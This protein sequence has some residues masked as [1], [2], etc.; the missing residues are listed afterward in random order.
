MHLDNEASPE[1]H[2]LLKEKNINY[3]LAPPGMYRKNAAERAIDTFKDHFIAV[4]CATDPDLLM[5]NRDHLIK[6]GD[7]I[8]KLLLSSRLNPILFPYAHLNG[9]FYFNQNPMD[10][11]GKKI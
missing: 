4:L 10:S 5:Q 6:Q 8:I 11:P 1:F 3:Q 7:I 9:D 2:A